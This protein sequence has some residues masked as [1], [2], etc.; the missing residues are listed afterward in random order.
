MSTAQRRADHAA[1][2][3]AD[4]HGNRKRTGLGIGVGTADIKT[5][6]GI[7]RDD[8]ARRG[9]VALVDGRLEA[10][11]RRA[12]RRPGDRGH[13]ARARLAGGCLHRQQREEPAVGNPATSRPLVLRRRRSFIF[14][15]DQRN[16]G[17]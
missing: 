2:L 10:G 16:P 17:S 1:G 7:G 8:S 6:V 5:A 13:D 3:I 12:C 9:A 14:Y 11:G 4:A 15:Q